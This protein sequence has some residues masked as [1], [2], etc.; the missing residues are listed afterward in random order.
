MR[1]PILATIASCAVHA[2]AFGQC[3]FEPGYGAGEGV[4]YTSSTGSLDQVEFYDATA[5]PDGSVLAC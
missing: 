5:R 4:A 3:A 2:L 1:T